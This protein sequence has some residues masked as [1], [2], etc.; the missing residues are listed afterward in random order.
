M[1]APT[2][3]RLEESLPYR[4]D[5]EIENDPSMK[6][7]VL[8]LYLP[9]EGVSGFASVVWFHGG[10][11]TGGDKE[12][13]EGLKNAGL[14]VLGVRYRLAPNV[15]CVD[16]LDDAAA[17][18]AWAFKNIGRFGGDVAKIFVSGHSAGGY[19]SSMIGLDKRW[20]A[21]YGVDRRR[22]RGARAS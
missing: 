13:P 3:Y 9:P 21:K 5:S 18:V 14:A 12:I 22:H 7:C 10:G 16:C 4:G 1:N 2:A 8:D 11:L 15:R 6:D 20:L 17:A 19:I